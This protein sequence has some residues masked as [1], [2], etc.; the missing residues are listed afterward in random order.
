MPYKIS[1]DGL[2]VLKEDGTTV[3]CHDTHAQAM[4]HMRALMANVPE[5]HSVVIDEFVNVKPGEAYRLFPFGKIVKGG[6]VRNITPEFAATIKLPHFK[7]AIKLGSHDDTTPAGGH[8][9]ALEVRQDGLYAIPEFNDKG[10]Q[11]LLDGAFRYHSPEIIWEGGLEDPNGGGAITA[12]LIMGDAL[13]HTPHLGEAA[14]L[15]S[16]E[17]I[18]PN[19]E[20][21]M[22]GENFTV[23][24]NIWE[25]YIAPLFNKPPEIKEVVKVVEPE[26]YATTKSELEQFKAQI[27]QQKAESLKKARIEKYEGELKETKAPVTLAGIIAGLNDEDASAVMKEIRAMSEQ[28]NVSAIA[29]ETG[30]PADGGALDDPKAAFNAE[31]LKL[32]DPAKNIDYNAA[33]ELVKTAKPDLFNAWAKRK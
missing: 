17:V 16:V 14:A 4:A 20:Q 10:S 9:M 2:C 13:L 27:E 5:A 1:E 31:V 21:N 19:K 18:E 8:I 12:P 6:K 26:D 28:I 32:V 11:A 15:Y 29:G 22:N 23:P 3:K 30:S 24:M 33:F 25:K 7:P